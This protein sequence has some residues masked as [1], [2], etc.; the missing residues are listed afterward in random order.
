MYNSSINRKS[1]R[2]SVKSDMSLEIEQ[3]L[4]G[5]KELEELPPLRLLLDL[6]GDGGVGGE[7]LLHRHHLRQAVHEGLELAHRVRI[8]ALLV[9]RREGLGLSAR[10]SGKIESIEHNLSCALKAQ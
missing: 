4:L 2:Q 1:R 6:L 7:R 8:L 3:L 9:L 5:L 10:R